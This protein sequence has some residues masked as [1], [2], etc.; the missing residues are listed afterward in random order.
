MIKREKHNSP[1]YPENI[2]TIV[3]EGTKFKGTLS[4]DG[5]ARIDGN[6]EG[7]IISKGTLIVGENSVIKADIK[8]DSITVGGKV[9]GNITAI[10]R[11][12][13]LSGAEINGNIQAPNLQ[14]EEGAKFEG[15]CEMRP[16]VKEAKLISHSKTDNSEKA[17]LPA[18]NKTL[19]EAA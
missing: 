11:L 4:F 7:E 9:C 15:T 2:R 5:S 10:S 1:S 6:M 14:I 19:K 17:E 3:G 16:D 13:V 12:V 18:N 8:V